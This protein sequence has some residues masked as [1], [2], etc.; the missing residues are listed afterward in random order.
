MQ[1]AMLNAVADQ[2]SDSDASPLT[3]TMPGQRLKVLIMDDNAFDRKAIT[4]LSTK[5]RFNL[6]LIE[7]TSIADARLKIADEQPDVVF[8]DYRVPDGDGIEFSTELS[9]E[10]KSDAPPVVIVT[11]EG[12]EGTVLRSFR[13]GVADYLSKDSLSIEAFDGSIQ[14]CLAARPTNTVDL[15]NEIDKVS[16]E[17]T[18]LREKTRDNMRLAR[19]VMLPMAEYAWRSVKP[20]EGA[21]RQSEAQRLKQIT[22]RLAG[23]LDDTLIDAVT[24]TDDGSREQI[25]LHPLLIEVIE[26]APEIAKF[27]QVDPPSSFPAI[28]AN[29]AQFTLMIKELLSEAF[30]V[31]PTERKPHVR[32]HCAADKTGNPVLCITDNGMTMAERK[33]ELAEFTRAVG[34]NADNP[35]AHASH[36][37]VCQRLADLNGGQLRMKDGDDGGCVVMIRFPRRLKLLH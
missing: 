14:R 25:D 12:D 15:M 30:K 7:A 9:Y 17:L 22:Q 11:G 26:S 36:M 33:A 16:G 24:A 1:N 18:S 28:H 4:R 5:S 35:P 23:A 20:L 3:Y 31:V 19:T 10:L 34:D 13:S 32:I 2:P 29:R 21:E 8:L 27:V 37:S 6:N